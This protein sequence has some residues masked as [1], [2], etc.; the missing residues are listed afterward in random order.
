MKHF[1]PPE[2]W[3]CYD[4]LPEAVQRLADKN[5]ELLKSN[6]QHPSLH[7]KKIGRLRS[8]RVGIQY[9][10][11]AVEDGDDLVWFWIGPHGEYD[12]IL[13]KK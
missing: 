7:F 5:F 1:A 6:P 8:A 10:A 2:F 3:E 4:R 12:R 13:G 11:L 9:R